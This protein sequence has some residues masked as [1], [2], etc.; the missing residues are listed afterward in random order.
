MKK[1]LVSIGLLIFSS[2]SV[3]AESD[4]DNAS[5]LLKQKLS[6]LNH[7]QAQFHQSVTDDAGDVVHE[8]DG[9][10]TLVRP[11]KLRW[12][13]NAPNETVLIADGDAV[14]NVD[15]FV[16][17]VT[18][19]SQQQAVQDNPIVLLTSSDDAVWQ[20]YTISVLDKK[21]E[22]FLVK[23]VKGQGQIS[24]L[25]L[26]FTDGQLSSMTF[27]DAQSQQ[28]ALTFTDINTEFSV[29]PAMFSA[30]VPDHY[31]VDDQR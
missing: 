3:F 13:T 25:S 11:D 26:K 24:A 10:L 9:T 30:D 22:T 7:Y 18:V 14:W 28:S 31:M 8:A 27:Q 23:P 19:I 6:T 5:A 20:D 1:Y 21:G 15:P 2:A 16:E 4:N 29:T 17:Q 12:Q